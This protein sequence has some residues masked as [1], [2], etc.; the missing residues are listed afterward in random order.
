MPSVVRRTRVREWRRGWQSQPCCHLYNPLS[1]IPRGRIPEP[2]LCLI[3]L[4]ANLS[5]LRF[6]FNQLRHFSN[7]LSR[8]SCTPL[9][10]SSTTPPATDRATRDRWSLRCLGRSYGVLSFFPPRGP[11][12][13]LSTSL[14]GTQTACALGTLPF[15]LCERWRWRNINRTLKRRS[16]KEIPFILFERWRRKDKMGPCKLNSQTAFALLIRRPCITLQTCGRIR[17][18]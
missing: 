3:C 8:T 5:Y 7:S 13:R 10:H 17:Q 11:L 4:M 16:A 1:T 18:P 9:V 15:T 2:L 14:S 12:E 6:T